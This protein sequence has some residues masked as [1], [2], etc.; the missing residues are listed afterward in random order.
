MSA[1][2]FRSVLCGTYSD[3]ACGIFMFRGTHI[4]F[5]C[6]I[7]CPLMSTDICGSYFGFAC[8]LSE[9]FFSPSLEG[10]FVRG[11]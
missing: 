1:D 9:A 6:E 11:V 8:G 5:A 4:C 10:Y 3:F 2:F 7:Y